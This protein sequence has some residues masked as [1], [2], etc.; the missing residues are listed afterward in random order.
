MERLSAA[1]CLLVLASG[2]W[3][4]QRLTPV[5]EVCVAAAAMLLLM[6]LEACP[7]VLCPSFVY[8]S[9]QSL[10]ADSNGGRSARRN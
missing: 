7:A 2:Q 3:R 1:T 6:I 10:P 4:G 8:G 9:K 5:V